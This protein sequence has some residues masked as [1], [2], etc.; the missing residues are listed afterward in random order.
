MWRLACQH[1]SLAKA[2]RTT[3]VAVGRAR[4][5]LTANAEHVA[6]MRHLGGRM[7]RIRSA[8]A[9]DVWSWCSLGNVTWLQKSSVVAKATVKRLDRTTGDGQDARLGAKRLPSNA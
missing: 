8:C 3:H 5:Q 2:G 4:G 6:Q 7:R 1:R 9:W